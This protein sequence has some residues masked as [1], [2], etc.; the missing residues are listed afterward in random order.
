VTLARTLVRT[1]GGVA[2]VDRFEA[3]TV[4]RGEAARFRPVTSEPD[5]ARYD[6]SVEPRI[7]LL[8]ID[9]GHV[10]VRP[11]IDGREVG[12]FA[13]DTGSG[14]GF[15]ILPRV[16]DAL[17][18]PRFGQIA[19][20]GAGTAVQIMSFR[21]GRTF[22]LGP[23]T[24][25]GSVYAELPDELNVTMKRLADIDV[26]G[27]CGYDLFRRFIVELD[28]AR[29]EVILHPRDGGPQP[30]A[31]FDLKLQRGI[32]SLRCRFEGR[33]GQFQ[34]D[35]GAGPLV[36]F[37]SPAVEELKLLEDRETETASIQGAAGSVESEVGKLAWI[38]IAGQR[39][40]DVPALFVT[41][42]M[43]ALADPHTQGTLGGILLAPK[44]LVFDYRRRRMAVL[45]RPPSPR[46][47]R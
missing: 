27:T 6:P 9:S 35:T 1:E 42:T 5:D 47:S 30:D 33:E 43:G 14:A 39:L 25:V 41:G 19:G 12:W 34:I 45:D 16:A 40:P 15:T 8:K 31:W 37:H 28:L 11:K 17:D 32:P 22:E 10:F 20:G 13:L 2:G 44:R 4:V 46:A 38:E 36:I 7:A 3:L 23:V 21:Q 26:V 18:L 24:I 29:A